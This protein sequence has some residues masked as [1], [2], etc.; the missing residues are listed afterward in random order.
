[1]LP[2][3]QRIPFAKVYKRLSGPT[4][5]REKAE[6]SAVLVLEWWQ[7]MLVAIGWSS[8]GGPDGWWRRDF[9]TKDSANG[10]SI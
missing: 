7:L 1:M 3:T 4:S 9:S 8:A 10:C 6:W 5:R 2:R